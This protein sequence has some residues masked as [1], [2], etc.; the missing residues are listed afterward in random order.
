[1]KR[2]LTTSLLLLAA[3]WSTGQIVG[4][5]SYLMGNVAEIG[6]YGPGGYEGAQTGLGTIPGLNQRNVMTLHGF[7]ADPGATGWVNFDGDFFTPGSPEN[8]WGFSIGTALNAN[9]NC[10]GTL[11]QIPGAMTGHTVTG[12][13]IETFWCGNYVGSGYDLSWCIDYKL[14]M[15]DPFYTTTVTVTNNGAATVND[16]YYLRNVDPDNNQPLSFDFTTQNTIVSQPTPGCEKA[17]VSA[18]QATPWPSYLGLGA[19][20]ANWRA[21]FGGF[22]NRNAYNVWN[23]IGFTQAVGATNFMDEAISLAYWIPTLAA[24]ASETFDFVIIMDAAQAD[25]ALADLFYFDYS[26]GLGGPPASDCVPT[27]DTAF[28]CSGLPVTINVDGPAMGDFNWTWSPA[29]GLSTTT[30]PTTDASPTTT[31]TYTVTGT[32]INPCYATNIVMNIVVDVTAGPDILI[33]DPGPQCAPGPFDLTTLTVTDLNATPGTTTT[34]HSA[35]PTSA[36]DM[37]NLWPGTTMMQG[38]VVYV[39]IGDPVMGCYDYEQIII[40][41][42]T[43]T[44]TEAFTIETCAGDNDATITLT[45]A[46]GTSPYTYDIGF[47]PTNTTGSFTNLPP[48]TYN[49]TITDANGCMVTGTIVIGPGPSCCPMTN[50]VAFTDPL[51]AGACDGTITL[52]ESM[53]APPVQ[54][55]IDN[56]GTFQPT[57]NFA[58]VCAGTYD[59]LIEDANGCQYIDQVTLTDPPGVTVTTTSADALCNG[60]CDG[61]V[62]AT[63]AGG[64]GVLT[65][66]WTTLGAGQ[67]FTGTVCAGTYTVT[68][69]DANGCTATAPATVNE[70]TP[71]TGAVTGT[72]DATCGVANGQ[73]TVIGS[74]GTSPY[75][76]DIGG[77][78]QPTGIFGSLL[79]GTYNVTITDANGCTV[80]VPF[81]I[82]DLSGLT[83]TITAQTNASCIGACDG[84]VTVVGS[85]STSPYTY[86]IGGG[87][88]PSGT[89][90]GLCAGPYTVTV[91]DGNGCTF[92]VN[93]TITEPTAVG[94]SITGQTDVSCNGLCDG[95]VDVAG[96]GGTT[97]YMYDIGGGPQASGS[98][99]GLCAGANDVTVIDANGCTFVIPVTIIEPTAL[100]GAITGQ[101]DALCNGSCDG[102]VT[103]AGSGGISPYTYDIGGGPQASGTFGGLC[104]GAHNVTVIDANGC[105]FVVPVTINEPTLITLT[106]SMTSSNCGQMDGSVDVVA[107]GGTVGVDYTYEWTDALGG[108]VGTTANV[109][110]LGGGTYTICVTDDNGCQVCDT[111]TITDLGGGTV[112]L[113]VTSNYNGSEVSCNGYCDGEITATMAGGTSPYTYDILGVNNTTGIFNGLC[114]GTHTVTVTDAVGCI[115]SAAITITDPPVVTV[116]TTVVHETCIGDCTGSID[117]V[118]AGGT[119]PYQY[120]ID[121]CTTFQPT[122]LFNGLC[123]GTYD[124]CVDDANGCK[125]FVTVT[126]DPGAAFANAAIDPAGPYCED[127]PPATMTAASS[128][129]TWSGTGITDPV[130]GTFDPATAGPGTHTITYTITGACGGSDTEDIIVNPLPTISFNADVTSGCEPLTVTFTNTGATGTCMW[131]F[132]DGNSSMVCSPVTHT[133]ANPGTYDVTLTVTDANGCTNTLV[134]PGY[135]TVYA[136]PVAAFTFGPQPTS[137]LYPTINFTDQS[138]AA[139]SWEWDFAGLG[140]SNLQNP[141][142][143][144]TDVGAY[145]V[146]LVVTSAGGCTD[147]IVNTIFIGDEFLI[148]VPNAI[149]ADGDGLNDVFTPS[150]NGIDPLTYE[151]FIFDRWGELIFQANNPAIGWDGT[152]KGTAVQQDVYVWKILVKDNVYGDQH[153]YIGHVTVLK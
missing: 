83:A 9:N 13:C 153:E 105:T 149:T 135:I 128:G 4:P 145:D 33:T 63:G 90:T 58:G 29:T 144:F 73:G 152:F 93:V 24:G 103:I 8:G 11:V 46:G 88:Q 126:V 112:T 125:A 25:A 102:T 82:M 130:N 110:G 85:G 72:V 97:P 32:P 81:T 115:A 136:N 123:A 129:G 98:F 132:G 109:T 77:G 45:A 38:D 49:Y 18:T 14:N 101:T 151:L 71:L 139:S 137:I 35:P 19:I 116:T 52:T 113:N 28:T 67:N 91:T 148:Y 118:G 66:T 96:S 15:N 111:E 79:P 1:M 61:S 5:N 106:T 21:T 104:A 80:I 122:G 150:L 75:T 133:Y 51:C 17:L 70:P 43:V 74:G 10:S 69:T 42:V 99:T 107:T 114:S 92:P 94:G 30:G 50:T 26:G 86:D 37:T 16:L 20:G 56:G 36:T 89:F 131:D 22:A 65:Y 64:T 138:V 34:F 41:W 6:V 12:D 142:F 7:V 84:S 120:S 54:Y 124:V 140:A 59:I 31:T 39:M 119:P 117:V 68:V 134:M 40:T 2:L 87:P 3:I 53:G 47:G 121:N 100:G 78:P 108:V 23:N 76:Y 55:S 48:N 147:T 141:S 27:V 57:G 146:T 44:A 62:G 127:A 143:E 95:T 60:S